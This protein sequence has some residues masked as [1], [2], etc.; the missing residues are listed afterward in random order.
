M[1]V[2]SVVNILAFV[3][4]LKATL[5]HTEMHGVHVDISWKWLI[6]CNFCH[7]CVVILEDGHLDLYFLASPFTNRFDKARESGVTIDG[8]VNTKS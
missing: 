5:T 6:L 4:N 2:T 1:Q 3:S 8:L 7:F